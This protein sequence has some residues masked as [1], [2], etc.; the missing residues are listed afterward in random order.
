MPGLSKTQL[1]DLLNQPDA[2]ERAL[3]KDRLIDFVHFAWSSLEPAIPFIAS[4]AVECVAEHLQ[5]VTSGEIRHIVINVPPGCTKSMLTNVFWPAW[6]WGPKGLPHHRFISA[7]YDKGLATRDLVRCRDLIKDEWYSKWWPMQFKADQD[8]KTFYENTDTGWRFAAS[9][10][11]ALTGYRGDRIIIDDPHD[12]RKAESD[13]EREDGIRWLTETVPT[14]YNKQAESAQVII[15]QRLH[16]RDASGLVIAELMEQGWEHL[17][18]PMEFEPKHCSYTR[19]N[20]GTP[21]IRG[22]K[23]KP[24]DD[25]VP[26]F[27]PCEGPGTGTFYRQDVRT[28]ENQLLDP[29][30]FPRESVEALKA[31]FRAGGGTYAEAAQLQQR[32]VPRSGGMFKKEHAQYLEPGDPSIIGRCA[33]GYDLAASETRTAKYTAGVKMYLTSDERIIIADVERYKASPFKVKEAI[34]SAAARDGITTLISIPQDPG[35]AGKAQVAE[36]AKVLHGY[37]VRFSPESGDKVVRASPL[38][39]QWEAGN[40]WLVRGAW[41]DA[42]VAELCMFPGGQ[43]SDQ[44]DAASRAYHEL[45]KKGGPGLAL[46][47]PTLFKG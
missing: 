4:P 13:V 11:G 19:V 44:V 43:F 17:C 3:C 24:L 46:L 33:R 10:G 7:S 34:K 39:S 36:F 37:V 41:N 32:P 38:A 25:P 26:I 16:E 12:V 29:V 30:R 42:F 2:W 27:E 14:R 23:V 9:V 35:Q 22:K 15:M 21:G 8:Q 20:N 31:T 45:L 5:A 18:L 1:A 47:P 40:V 6:E 28:E